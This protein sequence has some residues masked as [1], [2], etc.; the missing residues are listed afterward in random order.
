MFPQGLSLRWPPRGPDIREIR[1]NISALRMVVSIVLCLG[2]EIE[3][4]K[5][6]EVQVLLGAPLGARH[7]PQT[8]SHI[9]SEL[10]GHRGNS[11][12][13]VSVA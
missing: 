7:V 2:S 1:S 5:Q 4:G 3:L 11:Q 12:P 10:N 9:P 6:A 13:H 8:G